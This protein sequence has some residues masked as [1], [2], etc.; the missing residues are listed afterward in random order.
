MD[1]KLE[2]ITLHAPTD[3][4]YFNRLQASKE[5]SDFFRKHEDRNPELWEHRLMQHI[6]CHTMH[7][8]M[9][10]LTGWPL[11]HYL[12]PSESAKALRNAG[13][14][15]TPPTVGEFLTAFRQG[16]EEQMRESDERVKRFVS[17]IFDGS[18][19][20]PSASEGDSGDHPAPRADFSGILDH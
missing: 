15:V 3:P 14:S 13:V 8:L 7:I 1:D 17:K 18:S 5:R 20:T 16:H 11:E 10:A 12:T 4:D 2:K 19:E 6:G 9:T